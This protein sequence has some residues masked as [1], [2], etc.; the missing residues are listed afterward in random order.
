MKPILFNTEMVRAIQDDR[1]TTTRRIIKPQPKSKLAYVSAGHGHGKWHYPSEDAWKYWDDESFK[2]SENL[3]EEDLKQSWTPPAQHG[4]ILYVRET[5]FE[6]RGKY[7]YKA[8]EKHLG[9]NALIGGKEFFKWHPSIHMPKE[10]A[11]LFLRVTGVRVERLQE[12]SNQDV[13]REGVKP[14]WING[15][16]HCTAY[17]DGCLDEPCPNRDAY[18][19]SCHVTPFSELWDSTIPQKDLNRY[20]WNAN[21]WVWVIEFERISK[22]EALK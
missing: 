3:T 21:P 14:Q 4:D 20:G 17:Q 2:H 5:F 1:K 8:D 10:A 18:E 12:I 13:I 16:C 19:W 7:Y 9:L 6:V 11:R 22:E 15:G